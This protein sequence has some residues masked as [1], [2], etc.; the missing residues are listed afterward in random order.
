MYGALG[1]TYKYKPD[2]A[3]GVPNNFYTEL[4]VLTLAP[5][6]AYSLTPD[7]HVGLEIN[8]SYG[9][10]RYKTPAP[11]GRIKVDVRGGGL[12]GTVG[13][14]YTPTALLSLG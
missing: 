12:F 3:H 5:A 14:L 4:A 1:F 8:P 10:L 9:R 2:P 7:L 13:V 11:V 6:I